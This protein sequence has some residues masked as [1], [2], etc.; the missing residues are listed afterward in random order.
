MN[1]FKI[2]NFN[3]GDNFPPQVIAEIEINHNGSL[4]VAISMV[5]AVIKGLL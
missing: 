1:K 2:K 5:D 4:D 3:I